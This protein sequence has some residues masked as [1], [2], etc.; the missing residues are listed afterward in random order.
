MSIGT[1]ISTWLNGEQVGTDEFGNRYYQAKRQPKTGRRRR[2]VMYAGAVEPSAI[3]A[4]WHA[5]LHYTVDKPL[6]RDTRAKPWLREHQPNLTGTL[7]AYLP[8][9]HDLRGGKRERSS[10][11]Y[12]SWTP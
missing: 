11:D 4:E 9:G 3:P 7:G 1:R 5:W 6:E 2:W 12:E 10:A 8:P